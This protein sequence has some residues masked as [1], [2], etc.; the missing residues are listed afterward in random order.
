MPMIGDIGLNSAE[1]GQHKKAL[2]CAFKTNVV[3]LARLPQV[4]SASPL[5]T[6]RRIF[7]ADYAIK[8]LSTTLTS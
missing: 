5:A 1:F 2:T 7:N 6:L 3:A 4:C 8:L